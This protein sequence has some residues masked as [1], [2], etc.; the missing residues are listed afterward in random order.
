VS[1]VALDDRLV[2]SLSR[3]S[4]GR[5]WLE[6]FRISSGTRLGKVSVP[7]AAL[8]SLSV[9]GPW[10]LYRSAHA[11]RVLR[12]GSG[13]SW[14]VWRPAKDQLGARLLGRRVTWVEN[15][16]GKARLWTLRLPADD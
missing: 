12:T 2:A 13:K 14:T 15:G 6:W 3:G 9:G 1:A 8:P 10:I 7:A 5:V 16:G 4:A 11:S